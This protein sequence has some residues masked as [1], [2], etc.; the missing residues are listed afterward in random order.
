MTSTTPR[1]TGLT[2]DCADPDRLA[3]FWSQ[4]LHRPRSTEMAGEGW[5]SVGS[6]HDGV[7]RLTFQRVPEPKLGKVRLHLD[8]T[9][10]DLDAARSEIERLGGRWTG[11]RHDYD[12]GSVLTMQDPEGN[13][14]CIVSYRE[15]QHDLH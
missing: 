12:E 14:F 3:Q 15:W 13:E 10:P 6:R 2:I 5:A 9:V 8:V 1:W 4:L 7:P 11:E